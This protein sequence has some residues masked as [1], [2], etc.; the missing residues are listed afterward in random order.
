[1]SSS[2]SSS[3]VQRLYCHNCRRV[4]ASTRSDP[5]R[6][7]SCLGYFV[8]KWDSGVDKI[9]TPWSLEAERD[10]IMDAESTNVQASDSQSAAGEDMAPPDYPAPPIAIA[11]DIMEPAPRMEPADEAWNAV[12]RSRAASWWI[13]PSRDHQAMGRDAFDNSHPFGRGHEVVLGMDAMPFL[14][15]SS[16]AAAGRPSSG[17]GGNQQRN[18]VSPLERALLQQVLMATFNHA[19]MHSHATSPSILSRFRDVT[20]TQQDEQDECAICQCRYVCGDVLNRIRDAIPASTAALPRLAATSRFFS[21]HGALADKLKGIV[22]EAKSTGTYKSERIITSPQGA[23]LY[24]EGSKQREI[25][26]FCANNYLGLSNDPEL[27]AAAKETLG[28]HGFGLS[29]VRFICGTQDIHKKLEKTIAKF[30]GM[31]DCILF[32]SCFDANGGIFETLLGPEDAVISDALNHASIIDGIRL[33]KAQRFRYNHMDMD[34]LEARLEESKSANIRLIVT[35]GVFSMDGDVAPLDKIVELAK[36]YPNTYVM[37]DECHATGVFGANGR[38]T[39]DMFGVKV[40]II[41]S[42]LGKALGGATGG[43]TAASSDIIEVM[44]QKARPYLFSN[45]VAPS[46]VGASQVAFDRL[47]KTP[48]LQERLAKNTAYFRKSLNRA[49]FTILGDDRCPIV[50]VLLG[51]ARL[52]TQFADALLDRDIYVIGFSYPVVPKGQARIR[53]QLSAAHTEKQL[54]KAVAAFISV[55]KE[56]GV[57]E[58]ITGDA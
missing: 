44:R 41:N 21:T 54:Q 48:E 20:A 35:D 16:M 45:S 47:E 29:S 17:A 26:N 3:P 11:V 46:V 52:A 8:E 36:K 31:E 9:E 38:G 57:L 25:L 34:D 1:M 5:W 19:G 42:T 22:D 37:V 12:R 15:G 14:L 2:S 13:P 43:Y 50:P 10:E 28:S 33:C 32:P 7:N 56:L 27:V 24:V 53:V 30:H 23:S 49:G 18:G 4:T 58:P 39:P 40:D 6:C 55:G 51:D